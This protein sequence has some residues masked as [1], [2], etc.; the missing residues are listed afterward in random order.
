MISYDYKDASKLYGNTAEVK[1]ASKADE[2]RFNENGCRI[3]E[4]R[5]IDG[6]TLVFQDIH[7]ETLD[8]S[9]HSPVFPDNLIAIQHCREGRFEGVYPN[10][11]HIYMGPGRLSVNLPNLS[12]VSNSFPLKHYYGFYIAVIPDIANVSIKQLEQILG[13]L[14]IDFG[15][16]LEYMDVKNKLAFYPT[17]DRIDHLINHIYPSGESF[18]EEQ[19]GLHVLEFLQ[20]LSSKKPFSPDP[21]YY[22]SP[23]QART[24][25]EIKEYLTS[26]LDKH[27]SLAEL[28]AKFHISL[29]AMKSSFKEVYGQPIGKYIRNYRMQAS[30]ELLISTKMRIIDIACTVGYTN[31]S[32]FSEAFSEYY[33]TSPRE[34]R[35]YFCL[36]GAS[37]DIHE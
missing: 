33:G 2:L 16:I 11:E 14:K 21:K 31:A 1:I 28:S 20:I 25:K 8:Y 13:P 27:I 3:T 24:I 7:E 35:K 26:N 17:D 6:I 4:H 19:L 18:N 10:G 37:G 22:I 9:D 30:A 5:I 29:T 15:N 34:Y 32:K 36:P 23:D 12:P